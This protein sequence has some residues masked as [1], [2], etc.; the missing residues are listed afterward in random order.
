LGFSDL[1]ILFALTRTSLLLDDSPR[2]FLDYSYETDL[3]AA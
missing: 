3:K 1:P 2:H